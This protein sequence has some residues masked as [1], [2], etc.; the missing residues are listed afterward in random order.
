MRVDV[1]LNNQLGQFCA[2]LIFAILVNRDWLLMLV[3]IAAIGIAGVPEAG[4]VS[5]SLVLST[6]GLPLEILPL[7]ITVDW[8]LARMRTGV[9]VLADMTVSTV[10]DEMENREV[11]HHK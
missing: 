6:V 10:L 4:I 11:A 7:L 2:Y 9:N 1:L 5:L 3:C 8:I